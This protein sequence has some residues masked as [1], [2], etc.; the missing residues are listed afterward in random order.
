MNKPKF[1]PEWVWGWWH[2]VDF[3]QSHCLSEEKRPWQLNLTERE[4]FKQRLL[5]VFYGEKASTQKGQGLDLRH[6]REYQPG[7][8]L[9]KMDWNV[10]ARTATPHVREYFEEKQRIFWFVLDFS[11]SMWLGYAEPKIERLYW[12]M[13]AL[14][15]ALSKQGH[16]VGVL[17]FDAIGHEMIKPVA[18]YQGIQTL[19][20]RLRQRL[21]MLDGLQETQN[22]DDLNEKAFTDLEQLEQSL[23]TAMSSMVKMIG[24]G[25]RVVCVSDFNMPIV[26]RKSLELVLGRCQQKAPLLAVSLVSQHE[27]TFPKET[28][29]MALSGV[30]SCRKEGFELYYEGDEGTFLREWQE[31]KAQQFGE[32]CQWLALS[33]ELSLTEQVHQLFKA[34][35]GLEKS[36]K[37][38]APAK[39]GEPPNGTS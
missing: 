12:L 14:W 5:T 17:W 20:E 28:G 1:L 6:L 34:L 36:S 9:R 27:W 39:R 10:Y 37:A 32:A 7:D 29:L 11:P 15:P 2:P 22:Q 38:S 21:L 3:V 23:E 19:L 16:R 13:D 26:M 25:Q 8:D 24:R 4:H 18:G 33:V 31:G 35:M 30:Q